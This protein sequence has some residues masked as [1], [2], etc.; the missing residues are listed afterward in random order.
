MPERATMEELAE[1]AN[2]IRAA[3]GGNPL[4]ALMPSVPEDASQ[5]L[6]AKNLNFNC[7]VSEVEGCENP[8]DWTDGGWAMWVTDETLRD[9]IA[10]TLEL[11]KCNKREYIDYADVAKTDCF[12][13]VLPQSIGQVASD[14]DEAGSKLH[15]IN[16]E[17][18]FGDYAYYLDEEDE[19]VAL[20]KAA[21]NV[22]DSLSDEDRKFVADFLPYIE[23]AETEALQL[24]TIVNEDG[25]IVL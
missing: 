25:T 16:H 15:G 9:R 17:I 1:F 21:R 14:F 8:D 18:E 2:K 13:V 19:K 6:I 23:D 24:A 4:D 3:G 7:T 22:W 10:E 12:G 20:S 5:C 11:P